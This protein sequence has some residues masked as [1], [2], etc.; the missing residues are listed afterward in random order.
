MAS[1]DNINIA[2]LKLV[3]DQ[4]YSRT[5]SFTPAPFNKCIQFCLCNVGT[6]ESKPPFA[7]VNEQ[8]KSNHK[9][10]MG[11]DNLMFIMNLCQKVLYVKICLDF[12]ISE[13]MNVV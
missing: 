2:Q 13:N 7:F 11:C 4:A 12:H 8:Y 5:S 10:L 1:L 6:W 3:T 9:S